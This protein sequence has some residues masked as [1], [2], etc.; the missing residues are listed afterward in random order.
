V[1]RLV[2]PE[3][4]AAPD[5][6]PSPALLVLLCLLVLAATFGASYALTTYLR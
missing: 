6:K 2:E 3:V 1:T 4:V 5:V